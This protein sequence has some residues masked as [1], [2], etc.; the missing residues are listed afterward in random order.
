MSDFIFS[1]FPPIPVTVSPLFLIDTFHLCTFRSLILLIKGPLHASHRAPLLFLITSSHLNFLVRLHISSPP[2]FFSFSHLLHKFR[3]CSNNVKC[4]LFKTYCYQMYCCS[5]WSRYRN[6]SLNRIEVTYNNIIRRLMSLP[7]WCSASSM[8]VT[9]N[10]YSFHEVLRNV[11]FG[12]LSRLESSPN[13]I[14]S[15]LRNSDADV[16]S[17]FKK[18]CRS[19]LYVN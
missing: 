14:I 7:P 9:L 11:S 3:F 4:L 2:K 1:N 12:L 5:L 17:S 19:R 18:E 16:R 6:Y 13:M 10:V 8:F 15:N